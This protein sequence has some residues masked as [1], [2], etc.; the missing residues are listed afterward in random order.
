[1]VKE[2]LLLQI[3]F[4]DRFHIEPINVTAIPT[5]SWSMPL[6]IQVGTAVG[7]NPDNKLRAVC[8]KNG[9][10]MICLSMVKKIGLYGG[11]FDPIHL[12]ISI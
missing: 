10:E 11:T 6:L 4:Y 12:V 7:V 3:N 9:W 1:M 2:R 5:V 8:E